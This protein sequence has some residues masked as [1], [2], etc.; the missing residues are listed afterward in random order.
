MTSRRESTENH[1]SKSVKIRSVF[2]FIN[3]EGRRES[4][5]RRRQRKNS[6]LSNAQLC[7]LDPITVS[8]RFRVPSHGIKFSN[9]RNGGKTVLFCSSQRLVHKWQHE[10]RR[11]SSGAGFSTQFYRVSEDRGPF[12]VT[13]YF[14]CFSL[15]W[16]DYRLA[17][18][19]DQSCR[20]SKNPAK[21]KGYFV[22]YFQMF[23]FKPAK[24]IVLPEFRKAL[25]R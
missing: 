16:N 4:R 10:K 8:R 6:T 25:R 23:K 12:Y 22:E 5:R 1:R 20:L 3:G 24:D 11:R 7:Y 14:Q 21:Y 17:L 9:Q 19:V 18:F 2:L 15:N 13:Q